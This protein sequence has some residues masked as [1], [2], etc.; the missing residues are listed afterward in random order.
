VEVL[1]DVRKAKPRDQK[2]PKT[3]EL[4]TPGSGYTG[5]SKGIGHFFSGIKS[6][7][8]PWSKKS[9]SKEEEE[10]VEMSLLEEKDSED[11]PV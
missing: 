7:S 4:S 2:A 8:K 1:D 3:L 9:K 5:E 11:S 10:D 6:R